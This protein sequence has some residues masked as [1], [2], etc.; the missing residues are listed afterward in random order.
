MA[1]IASPASAAIPVRKVNA[2]SP[3]SELGNL[4]ALAALLQRV[5]RLSADLP[6]VTRLVLDPV[7]ATPGGAITVGARV[8][9]APYQSRPELAL[10]RLR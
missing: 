9:V 2:P 6:E 8:T 7:L 1:K 4:A 3:K 5:S 10:R